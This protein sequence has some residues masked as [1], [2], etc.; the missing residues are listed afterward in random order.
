MDL[1][2]MP[3]LTSIISYS[4]LIANKNEKNEYYI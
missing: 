1:K 3:A 4:L 2:N